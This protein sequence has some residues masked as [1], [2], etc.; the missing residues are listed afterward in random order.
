[1]IYVHFYFD[2]L[3][4]YLKDTYNSTIHKK[5]ISCLILQLFAKQ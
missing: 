1:M 2:K 5:Y 3:I 4:I